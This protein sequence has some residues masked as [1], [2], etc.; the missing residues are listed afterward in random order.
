MAEDGKEIP[1][2]TISPTDEM[3]GRNS[4]CRVAK[5]SDE[6]SSK[7]ESYCKLTALVI[8][9]VALVY[10]LLRG[11]QEGSILFHSFCIDI[12]DRTV[13]ERCVLVF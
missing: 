3:P 8:V 7:F 10:H 6:S 13:C 1:V 2:E 4:E 11:S 12:E 9:L 5:P